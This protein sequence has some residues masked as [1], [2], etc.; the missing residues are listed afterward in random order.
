MTSHAVFA[1]SSASR[2]FVCKGSI[3]MTADLEKRSSVYADE[4]TA[5]HMLIEECL[6]HGH[7]A[8]QYFGG[9]IKVREGV[10]F[11]VTDEM[12][13]ATQI[14]IDLVRGFVDDGYELRSEV[15]LDLG[16]LWPGQF[17]T[18]DAVLYKEETGD[19]Q[20]A[21]FKYGRGVVVEPEDNPQLL[22]YL[23]GAAKLYHNK[24][25]E[26]V[27]LHIVQ[28]RVPGGPV[29]TWDTTVERLA[30]FEAE[31][32]A[33]AEAASKPDAPLVAGDHCQFCPAA[34]FCPALH[35]ESLGIARAEFSADGGIELPSVEKLTPAE[36]GKVMDR[37][38]LV[39]A[40]CS[41]VREHALAAAL[42]GSI[43]D[44]W[45]LVAKKTNRRW[46]DE[47]KAASAL[48]SF[49]DLEDDALFVKKIISPAVAE[50]L[51]GKASAKGLDALV[52]RPPGGAT[53]VPLADKRKPLSVD[54][55]LEFET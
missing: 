11:P 38:A 45:K 9:T 17:G 41:S 42:D 3:R 54:A 24:A 49:Y 44:G 29:K 26:T 39:E 50:K 23:S 52:T 2:W 10:E 35:E 30:D 19:L 51:V 37:I 6:S 43:P 4:G 36:L 15:K 28:P 16:H 40:W 7:D 32:R 48:R 8:N 46:I 13:E 12:I 25:I 47:T 27:A 5:A 22:S 21:D 34:G 31:F 14:F 20:V 33:A 1:P 18:G 53:L 55:A